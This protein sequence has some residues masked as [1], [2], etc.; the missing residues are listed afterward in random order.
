MQDTGY[1]RQ[2]NNMEHG[3][4]ILDQGQEFIKQLILTYFFAIAVGK[5]RYL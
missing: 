1:K 3:S 4:C 5:E 2:I